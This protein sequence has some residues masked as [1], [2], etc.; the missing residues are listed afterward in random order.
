V[1]WRGLDHPPARFETAP[2]AH[3]RKEGP[4]PP[5]ETAFYTES[6]E[7]FQAKNDFGLWT[8]QSR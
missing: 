2:D 4:F 3:Q 7:T 1:P 5:Q 8:P 6:A